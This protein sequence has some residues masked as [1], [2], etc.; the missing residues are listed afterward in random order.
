MA[1][2]SHA[3]ARPKPPRDQARCTRR[4]FLAASA[5]AAGGAV[6]YGRWDAEHLETNE[7]ALPPDVLPGMEGVR[8]L[9]FSDLH[10]H[11]EL[12]AELVRRAPALRPDLIVFTGDFITDT[13]RLSRTRTF[14]E[15]LRELVRLAPVYAIL[16][17][18][19]M[20]KL[21][22]V[23]R[24]Y[25]TAGV[26][27]LRNEKVDW[28]APSGRT[29]RIIGLGDWTEGDERPDLCMQPR[30]AGERPPIL[31]LSHNPE[32]RHV[33]KNFAWDLMLAGH[34]HGGQIGNP[35]TGKCISFRSD[36]AGGLYQEDGRHVFV[37]R[38]VGSIG[39]MRFFCPPEINLI[40]CPAAPSL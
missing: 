29:L 37:T 39:N 1:D 23:A 30:D 35:F 6:F 8:I 9:H 26:T 21:D 14:I 7:T 5:L 2:D 33:L 34:T 17:N 32:S 10:Q 20:S 3:A 36:M 11:E 24:I 40:T 4:K 13:M 31:L 38:G 18:H 12:L 15:Q 19:D 28:A 16:G 27:L 25:Q 22:S